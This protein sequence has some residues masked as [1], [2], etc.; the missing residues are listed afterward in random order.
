MLSF[1]T[2]S[3]NEKIN[4]ILNTIKVKLIFK[5]VDKHI[6]ESMVDNVAQGQNA[7]WLFN[8]LTDIQAHVN[9]ICDEVNN[10]FEGY[11]ALWPDLHN[12]WSNFT[13]I[14]VD[15]NVPRINPLVVFGLN[16]QTEVRHMPNGQI[17]VFCCL[18][19]EVDWGR[20]FKV[21]G[22]VNVGERR[23]VS[24]GKATRY[25][26]WNG[27]MQG[28]MRWL[29]ATGMK[30]P[31]AWVTDH[32]LH[33]MD[34]QYVDDNEQRFNN[35]DMVQRSE[36]MRYGLHALSTQ[37]RDLTEY[38]NNRFET[39]QPNVG[40]IPDVPENQ[41]V[42]AGSNPD[43]IDDEV[44]EMDLANAFFQNVEKNQQHG[45]LEVNQAHPG[46][47]QL[48]NQNVE[49]VPEIDQ[50]QIPM[51]QIVYQEVE[52]S[53]EYC[54]FRIQ[55]SYQQIEQLSDQLTQLCDDRTRMLEEMPHAVR[56]RKKKN[57]NIFCPRPHLKY[58][59]E[60]CRRLREETKRKKEQKG[61]PIA[62]P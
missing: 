5:S 2:I 24:V 55:H 41:Q 34:Q 19:P 53:I 23:M 27:D 45:Q 40:Q 32:T 30:V 35:P 17:W 42:F 29:P 37:L 4:K 36:D 49:I 59:Q 46:Q 43:E 14:C 62:P 3:F 21:E 9:N 58:D 47:N 22:T 15:L 1:Q 25:G 11:R 38:V 7:D 54:T 60:K 26:K 56:I 13:E 8:E 31:Q 10:Q 48:V 44:D 39:L 51:E 20:V 16:R 6:S 57:D 28:I 33:F 61:T 18:Q 52:Q 50:V 12:L